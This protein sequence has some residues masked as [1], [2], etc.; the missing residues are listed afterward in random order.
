MAIVNATKVNREGADSLQTKSG[1]KVMSANLQLMTRVPSEDH[2]ERIGPI[3]MVPFTATYRTNF[4][5][6]K[7]R[8]GWAIA[9]ALP[10]VGHG[11]GMFMS[12]TDER[13]NDAECAAAHGVEF[14]HNFKATNQ[15]EGGSR[16][17]G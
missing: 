9:V 16:W 5:S 4:T 3:L 13:E 1:Q 6:I 8:C 12:S 10:A 7:I 17:G 14:F 15:D 11:P 2:V